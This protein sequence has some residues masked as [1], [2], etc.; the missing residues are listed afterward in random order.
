M[1][2]KYLLIS[3]EDDRA[4]NL[5]GILG[6]KTCKKII[7]LLAEKN[8]AS[9]KDIADEL[10]LPINTIEYNLKKLLSA[11]LIEKA[12][13]FFWSKKGKKI[14]MYRLS[15]KSIIISPDSSRVSS[16]IKSILPI[17]LISGV[18][19]ILIQKI[20]A[21]KDVIQNEVAPR[22][23][24]TMA[25]GAKLAEESSQSFFQGTASTSYPLIGIWFLIGAIFATLMM[26]ILNWRKL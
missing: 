7:D 25:A 13:N 5:S 11:E 15:N 17:V 9:E 23:S 12:K 18:G 1:E 10:K 14:P 4:K 6:N 26:I 20:F 16:K 24:D 19:A 21:V 8:Q 3:I 2:K 22:A